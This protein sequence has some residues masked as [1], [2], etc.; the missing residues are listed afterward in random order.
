MTNDNPAIFLDRDGTINED[1]LHRLAPLLGEAI[2]YQF[3]PQCAEIDGSESVADEFPP[4]K[5]AKT[6]KVGLVAGVRNWLASRREKREQ[7][8]RDRSQ[9]ELNRCS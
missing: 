8:E 7:K 9:Q 3:S 6:S 5:E 1:E 4:R 2:A